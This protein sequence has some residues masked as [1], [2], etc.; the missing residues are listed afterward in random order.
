MQGAFFRL[1]VLVIMIQSIRM[2][3]VLM[4]SQERG[5][6]SV[7]PVAPGAVT[8]YQTMRCGLGS[9]WMLPACAILTAP[10]ALSGH[11]FAWMLMN[12]GVLGVWCAALTLSAVVFMGAIGV[13]ESER[14]VPVL[15]LLRGANPREQAALIYAPGVVLLV[16]GSVVAFVGYGMSEMLY[17]RVVGGVLLS[18][19][20]ILSVV[21]AWMCV[22]AGRA[23]WF[24]ATSVLSISTHGM[25]RWNIQTNHCVSIWIGHYGSSLP[26]SLF[27]P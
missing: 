16:L 18:A 23:G 10:L 4:R 3:G 2:H 11:V 1:G 24:R 8:L 12:L 13:A 6:L 21:F 26:T 22:P 15:D 25:V 20:F 19:P 17:G 27:G 9:A 7:H 5:V 14:W